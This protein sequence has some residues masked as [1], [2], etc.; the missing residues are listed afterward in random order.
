MIYTVRE[1][2]CYSVLFKVQKQISNL[3]ALCFDVAQYLP[4]CVY[5]VPFEMIIFCCFDEKNVDLFFK[6]IKDFFNG[7]HTRDIPWN[8]KLLLEVCQPAN[9]YTARGSHEIDVWRKVSPF[10][11]LLHHKQLINE[12]Y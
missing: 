6:K 11:L 1:K 9:L 5:V 4:F 2:M 7:A 10:S 8:L 3:Q 12:T